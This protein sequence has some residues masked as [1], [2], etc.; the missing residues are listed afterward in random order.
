MSGIG[1]TRQFNGAVSNDAF[2][3]RAAATTYRDGQAKEGRYFSSAKVGSGAVSGRCQG[4]QVGWRRVAR[5]VIA[6]DAVA[7]KA[8]PAHR[9]GSI[10][11][12][13]FARR[14]GC[15]RT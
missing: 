8:D 12:K 5:S 9:G 10:V 1:T 7:P 6:N 2:G 15:S 11:V 4:P 14:A 13:I 3:A